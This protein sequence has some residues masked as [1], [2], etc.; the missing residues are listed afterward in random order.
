M[1]CLKV[2]IFVDFK[3]YFVNMKPLLNFNRRI[4][5]ENNKNADTWKITMKQALENGCLINFN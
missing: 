1:V 5:M 3:I 2:N 4:S